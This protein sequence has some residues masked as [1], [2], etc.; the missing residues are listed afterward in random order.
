MN[1]VLKINI[2]EFNNKYYIQKQGTAMGTRMAPSYANLFMGTL[3]TEL[4]KQ[5]SKNIQIWKRFIDDIFII[6]MDR[7]TRRFHG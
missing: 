2:F 5:S 6:I 4:V 7:N 1:I 3:E